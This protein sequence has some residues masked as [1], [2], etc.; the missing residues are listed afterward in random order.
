MNTID[1]RDFDGI[2]KRVAEL[3]DTP[4]TGATTGRRP[5]QALLAASALMAGSP[6]YSMWV[7]AAQEQESRDV[8]DRI[9]GKDAAHV[10]VDEFNHQLAFY[11]EAIAKSPGW[12]W[13]T[14]RTRNLSHR[15]VAGARKRKAALKHAARARRFAVA[16]R[17][18]R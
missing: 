6:F 9:L 3:G 13:A 5:Y 1:G 11:A 14:W 18:Y 8:R 4:V 17:S 10:A 12:A 15:P 16:E 2:E 7:R